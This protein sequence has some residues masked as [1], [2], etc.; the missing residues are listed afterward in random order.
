MAVR[1]RLKR[2]GRKNLAFYRLGA[3]DSRTRRDGRAIEELGHY[4]PLQEKQE[5]K[6]ALKRERIEYWLSKGALPSETVQSILLSQGIDVPTSGKTR[7]LSPEERVEKERAREEKRQKRE[8]AIQ[9]K[10]AMAVSKAPMSKKEK[11]EAKKAG[12][13]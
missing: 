8:E 5:K 3:F 11:R 6:Y 9:R 10:K 4:D 13:L 7:S 2:L 1:L 12:G